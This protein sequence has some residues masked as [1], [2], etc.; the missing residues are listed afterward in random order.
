MRFQKRSF[1]KTILAYIYQ[2]FGEATLVR[3]R[4]GKRTQFDPF[5]TDVL[6]VEYA[7][8]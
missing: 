2:K 5:A 1:F 4:S 8:N 6:E 7:M 3:Y